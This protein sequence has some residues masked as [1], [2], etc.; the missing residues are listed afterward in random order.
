[1]LL[2]GQLELPLNTSQ[3][4][5]HRRIQVQVNETIQTYDL[6]EALRGEIGKF[7]V[8]TAMGTRFIVTTLPGH[9]IS[10]L[11]VTTEGGTEQVIWI[12][13]VADFHAQ[14]NPQFRTHAA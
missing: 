11:K 14:P 4:N 7:E 9:S 2:I 3:S 12:R 10:N 5:F 6:A 8:T 13:K 1:M